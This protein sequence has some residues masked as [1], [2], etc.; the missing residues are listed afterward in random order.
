[1]PRVRL[2][3]GLAAVAGVCLF[4]VRSPSQT[5][6]ATPTPVPAPTPVGGA[7]HPTAHLPKL[8]PVAETKLLMEGINKPNFDALA[9]GL[10]QKPADAESWGYARGQALLIAETA[11]LLLIRPPK[12]RQA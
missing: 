1:M 4:A 6:S 10:K 7:T 11:N 5:K 9:K 3:T 2:V 8:V 12:T